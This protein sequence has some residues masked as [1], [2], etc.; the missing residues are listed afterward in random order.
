MGMEMPGR[1]CASIGGVAMAEMRGK[2]QAAVE[3]GADM[4]ELRLDT[5]L[6]P[7]NAP[8]DLP[9]L[10]LRCPLP[11]IVSVRPRWAGGLYDGDEHQRLQVLLLAAELG[12]LYVDVEFEVAPKFFANLR[13]RNSKVIISY[14]SCHKSL[15]ADELGGLAAKMQDMGAD[16]IKFVSIVEKIT[17]VAPMLQLHSLSNIPSI[18]LATGERGQISQLLSPKYG[19]F[20][21]MGSLDSCQELFPSQPILSRLTKVFQTFHVNESTE[22]FGLISCPVSHSIGPIIHNAAF[23]QVNHNGIYVPFLVD[24]LSE[25][26]KVYNGFNFSGFSIGIPYKA[27]ALKFCDEV[28]VSAQG[29]GAVNTIVRRKCD[30]KLIGYNTDCEA[31]ISAIEDGLTER[32]NTKTNVLQGKL[33]VLIGSG[34]AGKAIAFGAKQRGARVVVTDY[35]HERAEE[36]ANAVGGKALRLDMLDDFCP[37]SG[38]ILANASP[39]GM[40]PNVDRSPIKKKALQHYSLVFDAIYNPATTKLLREAAECGAA[41]VGGLEM[42]IRQATA[43]F[44]LFTGNHAPEKQMRQLISSLHKH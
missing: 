18:L 3:Q 1:L 7:F 34:G 15:T 6:A 2:M 44:E 24:D 36:L 43:Q 16:V 13:K 33:F 20:L 29:I 12:A 30:G 35:F 28:D 21:T 14:H 32:Q 40:H 22:V 42:F 23:T 9:S 31:A 38:M 39:V 5:I 37:E 26:F 41:V 17:D 19:G 25:F 10:L 11:A 4:V 27:D 8:H